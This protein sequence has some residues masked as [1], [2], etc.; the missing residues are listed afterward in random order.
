MH[1]L[2][3]LVV[4]V[5]LM[6]P[7]TGVAQHSVPKTMNYQGYL[8]DGSGNPVADG[9]YTLVF[10]LYD[11][12]MKQIWTETH[13]SVPVQKGLFRVILGGGTPPSALSLAF[14]Q[15][16]F[17]GIQVGS[18]PEFPSKVILNSVPYSF[19]S[20]MANDLVPDVI[21]D[22]HIRNTAAIQS[23]KLAPE[24][25]T[26]TELQEGSGIDITRS[27]GQLTIAVNKA[28]LVLDGDVTGP[29]NNT[30]IANGAVGTDKLANNAVTTGKLAPDAV[31]SDRIKNGDVTNED[32]QRDAVTSDKIKDGT[33]TASDLA[34]GAVT[35][36]KLGG[37]CCGSAAVEDNS[38]TADDLSVNVVSSLDGV[39]NDGGNIDLV[40]GANVTITPDDGANSIII[41]AQKGIDLPFSATESASSNVFSITNSSTG[42]A[43]RAYASNGTGILATGG[44]SSTISSPR[45]SVVSAVYAD[46]DNI[47]LGGRW[48][49]QPATAFWTRIS[50]KGNG[51]TLIKGPLSVNNTNNSYN[52]YVD[53][54]AAKTSGTA[55]LNTSDARLKNIDGTYERGLEAVLGLRPV[56][57]HYKPGNPLDLPSESPQIGFIAQE[58]QPLFPEAVIT[59][60]KG[61][62]NFDIHPVTVAMVN[63]IQELHAQLQEERSRVTELQGQIDELRTTVT[64]LASG[65]SNSG[66]AP[67]IRQ[68]SR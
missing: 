31:T 1:R 42:A 18:D 45:G 14:D 8:T 17:L 57:F 40:A 46:D 39:V 37:G 26:E 66:G 7:H 35:S 59:D 49:T 60:K 30:E 50:V 63:A 2:A 64:R 51:E 13:S 10:R 47:L 25:L 22:A 3:M 36:G 62:L 23:T 16:Y 15:Q 12:S 53:G 65:R 5:L 4:L 38:L 11:L 33:V 61:Y 41:S 48:N 9:N 68:A 28:S 32:L 44:G 67:V 24:I 55:W 19:R 20:V 52:F 43:I 6:T 21:S 29:L 27:S 56:R 34:D 54:T 58:V